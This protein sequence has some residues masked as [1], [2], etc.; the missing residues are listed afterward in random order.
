MKA[1]VWFN[2]LGRSDRSR[3]IGI[4]RRNLERKGWPMWARAAYT[5]GWLDQELRRAE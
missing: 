2:A 4:S 5:R 1:K 3:G